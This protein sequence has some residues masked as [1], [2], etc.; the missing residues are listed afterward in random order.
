MYESLLFSILKAREKEKGEIFPVVFKGKSLAEKPKEAGGGGDP[1]EGGRELDFVFQE[2]R[3]EGIGRRRYVHS[4]RGRRK[5]DRCV[6]KGGSAQAKGGGYC[7]FGAMKPDG[8][9]VG[10]RRGGGVPTAPTVEQQERLPSQLVAL[11]KSVTLVHE[12]LARY[13]KYAMVAHAVDH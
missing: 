2:K 6:G 3:R 12:A 11:S 8:G 9:T 1:L 13:N 10:V 4:R 5:E 7:N